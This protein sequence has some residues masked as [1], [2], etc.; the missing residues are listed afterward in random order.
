MEAF[1][2]IHVVL[3]N[4][5]G[6]S[7][8]FDVEPEC[9]VKD[10][11]ERIAEQWQIPTAVHEL[12]VES[13]VLNDTDQILLFCRPDVREV[14]MLFTVSLAGV[15][16]DVEAGVKQNCCCSHRHGGAELLT[17]RGCSCK[18]KRLQGLRCLVELGYTCDAE[19]IAI[20]SG[21]L[22]DPDMAVRKLAT[23]AL[24]VI[25][26]KGDVR[27][28]EVVV[29][30]IEHAALKGLFQNERHSPAE[31]LR[32]VAEKGDPNAIA[33][34]CK[35]LEHANYNVRT[36]GPPAV[37]VVAE[38]GSQHA[39]DALSAYRENANAQARL[40][41]VL[42][43]QAISRKGEANVVTALIDWLDDADVDV[44]CAVVTALGAIAED[45][46]RRV[47]LA[48]RS[49]LLDFRFN[50]PTRSF[51]ADALMS[52]FQISGSFEEGDIEAA[53]RGMETEFFFSCCKV[54]DAL[55]VAA[56]GGD[57]GAIDA[58]HLARATSTHNEQL[59]RH[60][61][62]IL[63]GLLIRSRMLD[64]VIARLAHRQ[65]GVRQSAVWVLRKARA[66]SRVV[67]C[68][69][70]RLQDD[71]PSVRRVAV[72]VL[73]L[74]VDRGDERA[75]DAVCS[76][77]MDVS[78]EI[79]LAVAYTFRLLAKKG[80]ERVIALLVNMLKDPEARVRQAAVEVLRALS[81]ARDTRVSVALVKQLEDP[82]VLV[83]R[84]AVEALPAIVGAVN[85]KALWKLSIL[86]A[87][88]HDAGVRFAAG[89]ALLNLMTKIRCGSWL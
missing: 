14:S 89:T 80:D 47:V 37:A 11:K 19:A 52:I 48:L 24:G 59:H 73:G 74:L 58:L 15:L 5:A 62:W 54:V 64:S 40:S 83:R 44:K 84:A 66:D 56:S 34:A 12:V 9:T 53:R 33:A 67:D 88:D 46:D 55:G 23:E 82:S 45:G 85:P 32:A 1:F 7:L 79:R 72:E 6:V 10:L 42:A 69:H 81:K 76:L 21:R 28:L 2:D 18:S 3:W 71:S 63:D 27:T 4:V 57:D 51:T 43:L 30:Q 26:E 16:A 78:F 13:V 35:L 68:L 22:S 87:V 38:K 17:T 61:G 36:I 29:A 20:V 8:E 49:Q 75:L 60:I 86:R 39:I 50:G 65:P 77:A 25:A 31:A 70:T 41:A